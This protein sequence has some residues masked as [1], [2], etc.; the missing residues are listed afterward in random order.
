MSGPHLS[1]GAVLPP[2]APPR[3][4]GRSA[5]RRRAR[6]APRWAARCSAASRRQVSLRAR[7]CRPLGAA[8]AGQGRAGPRPSGRGFLRSRPAPRSYRARGGG[9]NTVRPL[10]PSGA[11]RALREPGRNGDKQS[12]ERKPDGS[13]GP[14]AARPGGASARGGARCRGSGA[15]PYAALFVCRTAPRPHR[16]VPGIRPSATSWLQRKGMCGGGP[17]VSTASGSGEGLR[18]G[19]AL[20]P[21]RAVVADFLF[22]AVFDSFIFD[23][24]IIVF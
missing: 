11:R 5:G 3:T 12:P 9:G 1:G 13:A 14:G 16:R 18:V 17:G 23:D 8:Q 21:L 10:P 20:P 2:P 6:R 15:R 22:R 4:R 24:S 7:R 19:A